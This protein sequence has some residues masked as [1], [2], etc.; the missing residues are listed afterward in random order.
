[1]VSYS[2]LLECTHSFQQATSKLLEVD[3]TGSPLTGLLQ[4]QRATGLR[5]ALLLARST[6]HVRER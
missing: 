2:L 3:T 4:R 5:S 1:M 6:T